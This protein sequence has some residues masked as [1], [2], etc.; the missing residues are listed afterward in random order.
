[1][2]IQ[3]VPHIKTLTVCIAAC[4]YYIREV[5]FCIS[6]LYLRHGKREES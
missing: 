6:W 3:Y 4:L 1:M 5:D 2:D